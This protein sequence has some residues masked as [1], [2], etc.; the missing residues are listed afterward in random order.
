MQVSANPISTFSMLVLA[1]YQ[2]CNIKHLLPRQLGETSIYRKIVY[3]V[4]TFI[5]DNSW[6]DK[7]YIVLQNKKRDNSKNNMH[8]NQSIFLMYR[9]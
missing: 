5:L 7:K 2:N 6:V 8:A 9:Y 1:S 3:L 4:K